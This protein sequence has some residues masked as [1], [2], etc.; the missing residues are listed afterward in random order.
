MAGK[1][2]RMIVEHSLHPQ[3][4]SNTYVVAAED[5]GEALFIDAGGPMEPLFG[6]TERRSPKP[7]AILL[8]PHHSDHN[9]EVP[10]IHERWPHLPVYADPREE[11]EGAAAFED[12]TYAGL[13]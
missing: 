13:D 10:A 11:I 7:T 4:L 3:F 1:L 2:P 12:G 6:A 5:G 9:S 8:T